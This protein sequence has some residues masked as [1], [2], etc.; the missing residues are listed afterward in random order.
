MMQASGTGA[1]PVRRQPKGYTIVELMAVV[2]II[3]ITLTL[4]LPSFLDVI[5]TSQMSTRTNDFIAAVALTRSEATRRNRVAEICARASDT[6]CATSGGGA[7]WAQGWIVWADADDDATLDAPGEIVRIAGPSPN[8]TVTGTLLAVRFDRRGL[9]TNLRD[10]AL[11]DRQLALSHTACAPGKPL[12]RAI[13][14]ST[15]G[16]LTA[17]KEN[18]T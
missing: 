9:S 8:I 11:A 12:R 14:F 1:C 18:C 3:A 4:G 15:L 7:A 6:A 13:E 5:R 17:A 10:A 16:R 2:A